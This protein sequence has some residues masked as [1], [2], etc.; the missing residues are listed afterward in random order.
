MEIFTLSMNFIFIRSL[1]CHFR[2]KR[3]VML[4]S[5]VT[6]LCNVQFASYYSLQGFTFQLHFTD[7]CLKL[8]STFY[9]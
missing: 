1:I 6:G 4:G 8:V 9:K 7:L 2:M 5:S 3:V